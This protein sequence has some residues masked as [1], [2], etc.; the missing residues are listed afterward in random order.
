MRVRGAAGVLF[1]ACLLTLVLSACAHG[2]PFAG[3]WA[4]DGGLPPTAVISKAE[5]EDY[6]L[7]TIAPDSSSRVQL[8]FARHGDALTRSLT[9]HYP[10]PVGWATRTIAFERTGAGHLAYSDEAAGRVLL[11]ADLQRVDD[12]TGQPAPSG[13]TASP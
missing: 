10:R 8:R 12:A 5:A 6:Y 9:Q 3:T 2:D 11:R 13:P 7:V 4:V 1:A